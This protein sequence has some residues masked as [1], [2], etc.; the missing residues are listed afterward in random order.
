M[1]AVRVYRKLM[2]RTK[3]KDASKTYPLAIIRGGQEEVVDLTVENYPI[4][5]HF[6]IFLPPAL[7]EPEGYTSGIRITGE[8]TISFGS[9]PEKVLAELGATNILPTQ[10]W[11][12]VAF[13][14][15]LAKI[16]YGFAVAENQLV[17]I[18]GE[19]TVLPGIIGK[20][21]DIGRWVGTLTKPFQAYDGVLHRILIHQ[22]EQKG[23]LIGEVHLFS[24]SGA[25]SYGVILGKLR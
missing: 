7:L 4:L 1:W 17:L 25:P 20:A 6:P 23:L 21:D 5:L 24:D 11:H 16:A 15:M 12:P 14:R 19:A 3:H 22:D 18:E 13:A 10:T 2:S 8:A 9:R